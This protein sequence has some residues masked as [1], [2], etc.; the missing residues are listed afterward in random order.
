MFRELNASGYEHN[1]IFYNAEFEEI[2]SKVIICYRLMLSDN[3]TLRNDENS[4][5]DIL[6]INYLNRDAIRKSVGLQ[7]YYFDREILEDSTAGRTDIRILNAYSFLETAAYY[8]IECKRLDTKNTK[9]STGLNAKYI[10][11][12]ICRFAS[13][14]YSAHY[15]TNGMI[16]FVI[17]SLNISENVI[18]I[19]MLL[20]TTFTKSNTTQEL[21]YRELVAGF[22]FSYCS[23]HRIE[24]N[25]VVIYHLMLDFSKN[26]Q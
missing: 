9:G 7:Y 5:R 8:I 15:K 10:E 17:E 22:E 16:G 20:K 2:L 19:N 3:V 14:T 6:Y 13:K 21:K 12:G 4:I 26:I 18:S 23:A 25:N 1:G 24:K 11:N